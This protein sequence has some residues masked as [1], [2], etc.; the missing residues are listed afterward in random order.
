MHDTYHRHGYLHRPGILVNNSDRC[1][2]PGQ[3]VGSHETSRAGSD[4]DEA[5]SA[6]ST[7]LRTTYDQNIHRLSLAKALGALQ[8]FRHHRKASTEN[9]RRGRTDLMKEEFQLVLQKTGAEWLVAR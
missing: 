1:T 5:I 2:V 4:L 7:L 3:S 8:G 6:S 9:T